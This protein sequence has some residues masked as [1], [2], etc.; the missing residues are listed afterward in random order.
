MALLTKGFE[1]IEQMNRHFSEHGDDF[2]AR[3]AVEYEEM[4]DRFLSGDKSESM[5]ECTRACGMKLR[6]DQN[7]EAFGVLDRDRIIRTY[8]RPVPCSSL[9]GAIRE[10][11]RRA[12]RCHRHANNLVYVKLECAK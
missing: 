7:S 11:R 4:A 9:P 6:Y 2:G 10:S 1:S 5:H 12:G 8:F 3:S